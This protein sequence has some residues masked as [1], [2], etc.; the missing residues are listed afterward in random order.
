MTK[1]AVQAFVDK[2]P[3]NAAFSIIS[4]GS[5]HKVMLSQFDQ[6]LLVNDVN[7]KHAKQEI[8]KFEANMNGTNIKDPIEYAFKKIAR[9]KD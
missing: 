3:E 7:R 1:K 8:E 4:F 5:E 2:L 6:P 9:R